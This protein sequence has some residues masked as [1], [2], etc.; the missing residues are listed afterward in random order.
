M[1]VPSIPQRALPPE[2]VIDNPLPQQ[3]IFQRA[4]ASL[5][6]GDA[7]VAARI[8]LEGLQQY[9]DDA[10]LLC[11]A[12]RALIALGR[13]DEARMH[14][15]RAQTEYPDFYLAHE[16]LGE[17][18]LVEGRFEE[19]IKSFEEGLKLNRDASQIKQK[20]ARARELKHEADE[21]GGSRVV[22]AFAEDIARAEQLLSD[23]QP[24]QAEQIFRTV[25]RQDPNHVEAMRLL[26]DIAR[27]QEYY[28]DAELLL[29]QAVAK[30]PTYARAWLKLSET[31]LQLEKN[32]EAVDSA[33]KVVELAPEFAE[34]HI[35]LANALAKVDRMD[36]AI[37]NYEA[38]LAASPRHPGAFSGLAHQLKTVGRQTESIAVYRQ[39]IAVNPRSTE[40]Y[41]SLANFKTFRFRDEEVEA[42]ESLL[43]DDK[44]EDI[45]RVQL[46]NS[47]GL[48]YEGRKDYE[49]AF[50]YFQRC[51]STR[52]KAESY[53]PIANEV[54]T[55]KTIEIFDSAFLARHAN[56]GNPDPAPLFIVGLPRSGS[57]LLEQI[58]ASHSQVEGTH[59]LT[60]LA[61]TIRNL[62]R[63]GKR[64]QYPEIV[65]GLAPAAWQK[66]GSQYLE[67][68]AKYRSGLPC[69][70]DKNPN[71]FS[72]IG[73]ICL[74][75][76]K[77]KIV[78]AMRH[79]LDSCL[80]SY[81]QLFASG[82][83]FSYD[84]TDIGEY[85]LQ[86][87][88]L[89]AHWHQTLPGRVLDV[90][91]EEVV[92]DLEGQVRRLLAYCELPFEESCLNFHETDRAI[93]TAS[94]EQVRQPIYSSSRHL[95]RHYEPYL[96][97]LI[98]ILEPLLLPLP[99][100]SRPDSLREASHVP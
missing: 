29:K 53:D 92:D 86:Y 24:Q 57:T 23:G 65:S 28:D 35:A 74:A 56:L 98:D 51:N 61:R 83:P 69:F 87:Q 66:I 3:N 100:E 34:S 33:R 91:Y 81:K 22:M 68:T 37:E 79:P 41:W 43:R 12:A 48:E 60:D 14:A 13:L 27:S 39:S 46:C 32:F 31:Q 75:L 25:L 59:E 20:I 82:Q 19:A 36:E 64:L 99:P 21:A 11:I 88:R 72:Y 16:T 62:S 77:A 30:A 9:P 76:P 78:N 89:M 95:W 18:L 67:S 71:N 7:E 10:N 58:L 52:R 70:I 5:R 63:R 40:S 47:L 55:N 38:A 49:R 4:V 84:L 6:G 44:L 2:L 96:G 26:A 15:Q 97:E 90:N 94:S 42:M 17:L 80:G 73:L 85:Y 50:H 1:V 45:N 93:K 54:N 8:S